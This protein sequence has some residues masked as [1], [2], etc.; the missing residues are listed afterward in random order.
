MLVFQHRIPPSVDLVLD[1]A[2]PALIEATIVTNFTASPASIKLG[3]PNLE[4][5]S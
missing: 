3:S 5:G 4:P 2:T 1:L